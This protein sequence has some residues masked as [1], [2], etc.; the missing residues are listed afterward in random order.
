MACTDCL[1]AGLTL[2]GNGDPAFNPDPDGPLFVDPGNCFAGL[3]VRLPAGLVR[4]AEPV[5]LGAGQGLHMSTTGTLWVSQQG[6]VSLAAVFLGP[7]SHTVPTVTGDTL[8]ED[9][10]GS[11][12]NTS[13]RDRFYRMTAH[14]G[15]TTFGVAAGDDFRTQSRINV[16]SPSATYDTGWQTHT[17]SA[18]TSGTTPSGL[19][20]SQFA[21]QGSQ[22]DVML[23]PG[24]TLTVRWRRQISVASTTSSG[25]FIDTAGSVIN[26]VRLESGEDS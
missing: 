15:N 1:G 19:V 2:D 26:V 16:T 25:G 10:N 9:L 17:R 12:L 4:T 22:D 11:F 13:S 3:E 6:V 23:A 24:E 14:R 5:A 20:I 21:Q 7:N 8:V 18:V